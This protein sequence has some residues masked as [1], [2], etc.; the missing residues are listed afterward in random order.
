MSSALFWR[1]KLVIFCQS[2]YSLI[3]CDAPQPA[4]L[5]LSLNPSHKPRLLCWRQAWLRALAT[6]VRKLSNAAAV[7]AMYPVSQSLAIHAATASRRRAIHALKNQSYCE[8]APNNT[9]I[10]GSFGDKTQLSRRNIRSCNGY[11]SSH[12]SLHAKC[13]HRFRFLQNWKP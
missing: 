3:N 9:T 11:S 8:Y 7:V 4:G 12:L 6:S 10:S 1:L 2:Q 5:I 13:T